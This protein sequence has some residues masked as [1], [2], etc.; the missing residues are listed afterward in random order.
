[1]IISIKYFKTNYH[2]IKIEL[3]DDKLSRHNK[4]S[5]IKFK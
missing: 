1:M 2:N 3:E 5:H 4:K